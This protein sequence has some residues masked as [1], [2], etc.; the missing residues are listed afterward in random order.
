MPVLYHVAVPLFLILTVIVRVD[1]VTIVNGA[2][3]FC[4]IVVVSALYADAALHV[5]P[6]TVTAVPAL[7]V[8][9]PLTR[10]PGV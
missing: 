9:A 2:P 4:V 8:V 10:H 6:L 1:P 3:G 5:G 7:P